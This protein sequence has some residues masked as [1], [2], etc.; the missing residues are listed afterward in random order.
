MYCGHKIGSIILLANLKI[1]Y[2]Q[3]RSQGF[4]AK[5]KTFQCDIF[6]T[7]NCQTEE[8]NILG[9]SERALAL[10]KPVDL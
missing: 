2:R 7:E 8:A 10:G 3:I 5:F 4:Q 1:N 6:L 9:G